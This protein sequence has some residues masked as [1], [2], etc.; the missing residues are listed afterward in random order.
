L[1]LRAGG[2]HSDDRREDVIGGARDDHVTGRLAC[3]A[4]TCPLSPESGEHP[5]GVGDHRL[6]VTIAR[7]PVAIEQCLRFG[8][9]RERA[10]ADAWCIKTFAE[11]TDVVAPPGGVVVAVV[12]PRT[13]DSEAAANIGGIA[14]ASSATPPTRAAARLL[15]VCV[16]SVGMLRLRKP[17]ALPVAVLLA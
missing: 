10:V 9:E 16:A 14:A 5:V 3:R 6:A 11:D 12:V 1:V 13:G 15:I 4:A 2:L 17:P 7:V 8:S